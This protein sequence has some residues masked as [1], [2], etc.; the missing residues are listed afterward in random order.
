MLLNEYEMEPHGILPSSIFHLL[1]FVEFILKKE[2]IHLLYI[3]SE[4]N[5]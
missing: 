3:Q 5:K 2:M 1:T 4:P